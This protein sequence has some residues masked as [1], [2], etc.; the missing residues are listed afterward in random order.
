ME[1]KIKDALFILMVFAGGYILDY[2][3]HSTLGLV[4]MVGALVCMLLVLA[5]KGDGNPLQD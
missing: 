4:V 1:E 2:Y 5:E 3:F